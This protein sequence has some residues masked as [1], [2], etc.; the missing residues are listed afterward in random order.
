MNWPEII[1]RNWL[2]LEQQGNRPYSKNY[3][4]RLL[5]EADAVTLVS[6]TTGV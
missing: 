1:R 5:V 2:A 4:G 3:L 6:L